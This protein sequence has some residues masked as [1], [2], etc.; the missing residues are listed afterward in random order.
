M[1]ELQDTLREMLER[2][3]E[4]V[5]SHLEVPRSLRGRARRRIAMNA[6]VTVGVVVALGAGGL[7]GVRALQRAGAV[8]PGGGGGTTGRNPAPTSTS[9]AT[10]PACTSG[11][12]RAD[13]ALEGAMGSRE[14]AI[15]LSN[16]SSTT[17]TLQ[18]WPSI[19]LLDESLQ[20]IASG[21]QLQQT[22]PAWR[23]DDLPRPA[24]WPVVTLRPGQVA[25]VRARWSNWCPFGGATPVWRIGIPGSRS[26]DVYGI[27]GIGPPPCNGEG[28]PSTI[29]VGPF[30]PA[31]R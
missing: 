6:V 18:G 22:E 9:P 14:G 5:P 1:T 7:A 28:L 4:Q 21:I 30:E 27:D 12:L 11:Q 13:A 24:G 29:E 16:H 2:R 19:T 15:L 20:P 10:V 17:C 26:D 8:V 3:A 25:S 23:V 31:P